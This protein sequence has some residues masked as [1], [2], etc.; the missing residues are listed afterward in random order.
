MKYLHM[1]KNTKAILETGKM[2]NTCGNKTNNETPI[3]DDLAEI[4]R[5]AQE[6]EKLSEQATDCKGSA[7]FGKHQ[8]GT[9]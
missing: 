6:N 1:R 4:A 9:E 2:C 5:L 8:G 3:L 7:F